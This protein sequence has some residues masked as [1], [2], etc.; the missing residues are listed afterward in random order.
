METDLTELNGKCE[1]QIV[2]KDPTPKIITIV[3]CSVLVA[4]VIV[5]VFFCKYGVE[6]CKEMCYNRKIT[7]MGRNPTLSEVEK[8]SQGN[9]SSQN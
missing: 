5:T 2:K 8:Y 3:C 7:R 6:G 1:L 4:I 9:R